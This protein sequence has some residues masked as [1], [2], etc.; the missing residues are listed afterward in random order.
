MGNEK[1]CCMQSHSHISDLKGEKMEN[2]KLYPD[3]LEQA[4]LA[5]GVPENEVSTMIDILTYSLI[6]HL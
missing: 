3:L 2:E 1:V 5:E 6:A 4:I